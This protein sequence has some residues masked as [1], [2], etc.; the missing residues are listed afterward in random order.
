MYFEP[1]RVQVRILGFPFCLGVIF[2]IR[3]CCDTGNKQGFVLFLIMIFIFGGS[4]LCRSDLLC[5]VI[6]NVWSSS[7]SHL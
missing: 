7:L 3:I 2:Y 1:R 4:V 5:G 6:L